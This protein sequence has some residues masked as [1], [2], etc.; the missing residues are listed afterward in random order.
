MRVSL[1]VETVMVVRLDRRAALEEAAM[2]T[3][4]EKHEAPDSAEAVQA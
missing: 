3:L 2:E 1:K 4:V